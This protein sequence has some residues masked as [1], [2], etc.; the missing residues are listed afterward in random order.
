MTIPGRG[1][2][3][4]T[5]WE[6]KPYD[7]TDGAPKLAQARIGSTFDGDFT[8]EGT[9]ECLMVYTEETSA[10]FVG[11]QRVTGTVGDRQGSYVLE[12]TGTY[13]GGVAQADWSVV[14]GSGTGD[15]TGLRGTGGYVSREDG[16]C[17]TRLDYDFG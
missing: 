5:S 12:F 6:E 11:L 15:L 17:D 13:A 10:R 14:P 9:A 1:T 2:S 3:Q 8:G 4:V 16:V 7:E